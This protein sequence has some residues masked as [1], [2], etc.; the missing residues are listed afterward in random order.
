MTKSQEKKDTV[1]LIDAEASTQKEKAAVKAISK[2]DPSIFGDVVIEMTAIL[3]RGDMTVSQLVN[4]ECGGVVSLDT[5]LNGL[6]DL[7]FNDRAVARGEIVSVGDQFGV[8]ITEIIAS[9]A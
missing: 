4:L 2:V 5:P 1:D 6:V 8:R 9:K 3:G 7:K